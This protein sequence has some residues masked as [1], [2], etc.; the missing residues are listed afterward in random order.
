MAT[1]FTIVLLIVVLF[2]DYSYILW[3]LTSLVLTLYSWRATLCHEGLKEHG[4][5]SIRVA[6]SSSRRLF[7]SMFWFLYKT[8]GEFSTE[9]PL[10]YLVSSAFFIGL[11]YQFLSTETGLCSAQEYEHAICF[12][13]VLLSDRIDLVIVIASRFQTVQKLSTWS[14]IFLLR[15]RENPSTNIVPQCLTYV[16][17]RLHSEALGAIF[18]GM[19]SLPKNLPNGRSNMSFLRVWIRAAH[20]WGISKCP[21]SP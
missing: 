2:L 8:I 16:W 15:P 19:N 14:S 13:E 7:S 11:H 17:R 18:H 1:L 3:M 21:K 6:R 5:I 9:S 12:K 4:P 10:L 20:S